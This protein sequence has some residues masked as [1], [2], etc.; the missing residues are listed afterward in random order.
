MTSGL[1]DLRS[2]T[3]T[4][5][6]PEMRRAMAEAE[7]GDDCYGEDP[8]V[9]RL[10]DA[11]AGLLGMEAALFVPTGTM[12]N[13]IAIAVYAKRGGEV[14]C[15]SDCHLIHHE[16]GASALLSQVQ[17]RGIG[18]RAGVMDPDDVRA[19]LRPDDPFQPDT[20]L[21][22]LENTHNAAGG[23]VW[24]PEQVA[25]VAAVARE[26]GM[27]VALD[28]A[29]LFNA[30]A[31]TGAE[32]AA[33]ARHCDVVTLSLYKGLC[34]PM[35]SL[36]CGSAE[37]VERAWTYRRIFGGALRQAGVVAAAGLVGLETMRDRLH[38]DHA[39]ARR[40][41]EGLAEV[42]PEGCVPMDRVQTNMVVFDAARAGVDHTRLLAGLRE[43]GVLAGLIAPGL[44]RFVTHADVDAP[45]IDRASGVFAGVCRS[46]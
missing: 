8:T 37:M 5:P 23:T 42:A 28:G 11:A 1:V 44:V 6:T 30:C 34:A 2:D 13:Q 24:Q 45:A 36:V 43:E 46:L 35:G 12:A 4:V 38:T 7:V 17:L 19:A 29:R 15:E 14:I 18:G 20:V 40:L 9:N 3:V 33:Y 26:A 32:P 25:A 39:N 10:Q 31:A 21:V 41:A 22:A 27:P 16:S